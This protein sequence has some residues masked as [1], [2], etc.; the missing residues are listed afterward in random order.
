MKPKYHVFVCMNQRPDGHPKGSC[1][2]SGSASVIEAFSTEIEKRGGFDQIQL[3]GT[4]CMGPCNQGPTV[5]VYPDGVWYGRVT[6]RD[7]VDICDQH[8]DQGKP[9]E[10]LMLNL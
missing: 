3:T 4:F 8:F 6:A 9:V 10:R 2:T 1:R 5:V 7:V